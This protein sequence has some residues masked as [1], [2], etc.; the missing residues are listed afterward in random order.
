MLSTLNTVVTDLQ[1]G[2]LIS[3]AAWILLGGL[4][5]FVGS[6]VVNQTGHGLVR[7]ML[8]SI[9]G[10]IFGG[11]LA[12]LLGESQT[13]GLDRYSLFVAAVGAFVFLITYLGMFRRR[14]FLEWPG[15]DRRDSSILRREG[16]S[17][18]TSHNSH[19]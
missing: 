5:G 17:N 11:F 8:L 18:V 10:A 16:R 12:N 6:K 2:F 4:I 7:D 13:S 15:R 1:R 3:L 9:V 14:G 19:I